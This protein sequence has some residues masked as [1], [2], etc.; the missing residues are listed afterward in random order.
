MKIINIYV[1][2]VINIRYTNNITLMI[3][4]FKLDESLRTQQFLEL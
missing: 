2:N 1:N 3:S 4:L